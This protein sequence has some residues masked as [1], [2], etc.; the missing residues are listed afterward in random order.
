MLGD[1]EPLEDLVASSLV[2]LYDTCRVGQVNQLVGLGRFVSGLRYSSIALF[3]VGSPPDAIPVKVDVL[4]LGIAVFS[5]LKEH[6]AVQ[7]VLV[8]SRFDV[9][10]LPELLGVPSHLRVDVRDAV[11][12]PETAVFLGLGVTCTLNPIIGKGEPLLPG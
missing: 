6:L 12:G 10:S 2:Y 5:I 3:V 8:R 4:L 1:F 7:K 11:N 9:R